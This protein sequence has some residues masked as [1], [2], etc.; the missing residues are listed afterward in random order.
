MTTIRTGLGVDFHQLEEGR[1]F[2]LGGVEIPH[3]K[4]A[5]GH[6]DADVLLHAIA[7]ALLGAAGLEDIGH[8]FPDT[9]PSLKGLDSKVLL[10]ETA[11]LVREQGFDVVNVDATLCLQLP[12]IKP[13]IPA[14][15]AAI[16]AALGVET[17]Q[18]GIKATTTE[19]M[20][21]VGREEGVMAFATALL[22]RETGRP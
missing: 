15:K 20:G 16:A 13:F 6:S 9:D 21:F 5:V 18:V 1:T 22:D 17:G 10:R 3:T 12:R 7:D 2:M 4:G 11:A 8:Y 14:M 19:R